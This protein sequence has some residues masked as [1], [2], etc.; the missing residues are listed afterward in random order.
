MLLIVLRREFIFSL[1]RVRP[2]SFVVVSVVHRLV[3]YC[4]SLFLLVELEADKACDSDENEAANYDSCD[5]STR[6]A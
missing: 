4:C 5:G 6:Q 2:A 3:D 1:I